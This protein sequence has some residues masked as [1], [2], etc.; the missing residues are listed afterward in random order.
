MNNFGDTPNQI[1]PGHFH[2]GQGSDSRWKI[3]VFQH[4]YISPHY[5]GV[6]WHAKRPIWLPLLALYRNFCLLLPGEGACCC[7]PKCVRRTWTN[8]SGDTE[9]RAQATEAAA[10]RT[11]TALPLAAAEPSNSPVPRWVLTL[12]RCQGSRQDGGQRR[13]SIISIL[14]PRTWALKMTLGHGHHLELRHSNCCQ[15]GMRQWWLESW[16]Y[17]GDP[18]AR[19][20]FSHSPLRIWCTWWLVL[21][22]EYYKV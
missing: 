8:F 1:R 7:W 10:I 6:V 13:K 15:L 16:T 12:L 18:P 9:V 5:R 22:Q 2:D 11:S 14:L 21:L 3:A 20:W 17:S 19:C 4:C